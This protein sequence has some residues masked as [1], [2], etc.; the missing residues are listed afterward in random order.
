MW[1][2][3]KPEIIARLQEIMVHD[4]AGDPMTGLKWTRKTLEK[5]SNE[6]KSAGLSIS[7]NTVG[8]LLEKMDYRL[9][10]NHK[11]ISQSK[12]PDRDLQFRTIETMKRKFEG[13]PIISIDTK[14]KEQVGNFKNQG[15]V[16]TKTP[17]LVND[18]DFPSLGVGKAVPYGIYDLQANRAHVNVGVSHDTAQFA[19]DS[20]VTWWTAGGELRY[21]EAKELLVLADAGGSN[22]YRTRAWKYFLQKNLVDPFGISVTVCHYPPR[23][24]KWNP[25]EHRVFSVISRN[26]AGQPLVSFETILNYLKTTRT[27]TGLRVNAT[28]DTHTYPKG[29]EISD[30]EMKSLNLLP[31][32]VLPEWNYTLKPGQAKM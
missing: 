6:M 23:T 4:T 27:K 17:I 7:P 32:S 14:K 31:H 18:H 15:T 1:W 16:L 12:N 5:I 28:L 26:W 13:L 8:R 22:G 21:P 19:V 25:I 11:M 29:I 9:R 3:K 24:S 2:K 10:V 20:V 30:D